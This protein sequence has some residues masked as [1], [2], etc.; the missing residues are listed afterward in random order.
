MFL[1][2]INGTHPALFSPCEINLGVLSCDVMW[3]L[4]NMATVQINHLKSCRLLF[5]YLKQEDLMIFC[6][7]NVVILSSVHANMLLVA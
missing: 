5:L 6:H 7:V 4:C 1:N 3:Q 2:C